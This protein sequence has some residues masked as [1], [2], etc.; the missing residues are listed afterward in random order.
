MEITI[1]CEV[2]ARLANLA[3][4]NQNGY[5]RSIWL[6]NNNGKVI[7]VA[8]DRKIM[9]VEFLGEV[10]GV[11]FSMNAVVDDALVSQ[12]EIEKSIGSK[13]TFSHNPTL[14]YTTATTTLGYTFPGNASVIASDENMIARWRSCL[15]DKIPAISTGG[16]FTKMERLA[17]LA[18]TAPSGVVIFPEIIDVDV[19]VIVNDVHDP[20]W[21]GV[22]ISKPEGVE[23]PDAVTLP[24]WA[25]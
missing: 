1:S 2:F 7:A 10:A 24:G 9:A 21:F 4:L 11:D 13:I 19:P 25:R 6:E 16:M 12:C 15:P 20:N 17:I 22:F 8:T 3:K 23:T 14:N 5:L 18:K